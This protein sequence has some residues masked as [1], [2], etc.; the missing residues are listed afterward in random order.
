[1]ARGLGTCLLQFGDYN[2]QHTL[3]KAKRRVGTVTWVSRAEGE[4]TEALLGTWV[5]KPK[6]AFKGC[7]SWT[8]HGPR[9]QDGGCGVMFSSIHKG[10]PV[11][12][13][14]SAERCWRW[15]NKSEKTAVYHLHLGYCNL[16][17]SLLGSLKNPRQFPSEKKLDTS[18]SMRSR[19]TEKWVRAF[20]PFIST[21]SFLSPNEA[22]LQ[23]G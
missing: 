4:R 6:A 20:W 21:P 1:M 9:T 23:L 15:K 3:K 16:M 10:H 7:F 11:C 13:G 8:R 14:T 19:P 22:Q 2:I 12:D 5:E 17:Y 18:T